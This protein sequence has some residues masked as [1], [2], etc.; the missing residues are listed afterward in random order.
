MPQLQDLDRDLNHLIDKY[1][2]TPNIKEKNV[3]YNSIDIWMAPSSLEGLHIP[4]AEAMMTGCPVVSTKAKM[5]GVRDYIVDGES[6]I[7]SKNDIT[8]FLTNVEYLYNNV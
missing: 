8:E 3:F 1:I 5:A 2:K 6:G 7:L 4:P